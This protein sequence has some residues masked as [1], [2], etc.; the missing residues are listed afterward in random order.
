[1]SH[2]QA[3]ERDFDVLLIDD[4]CSFLTPRMVSVLKGSGV[5]V[6]GVY[7]PHDG[8][9]AKRRLLECG[10]SDVIE[11]DATPGEFLEKTMTVIAH[12]LP[13]A[14][15][16]QRSQRALTIG[17]TG[18]TAGV[19]MTEVAIGLAAAMSARKQSVLIDADQAW[20]SVAQR[21]DLPLHPNIRTALDHAMHEVSRLGESLQFVGELMVIGGRADEG[22]SP[23][24][25]RAELEGLLEAVSETAEVV[26]ADLGA[27]RDG[28]S[29]LMGGV[30]DTLIVVGTPDPV[31]VGRMLKLTRRL[32]ESHASLLMVL[33]RCPRGFDTA[34]SIAVLNRRLPG[35]PITTVPFD[36]KVKRA[37]W[38]GTQVD[39]GRFV[40]AMGGFTDV[41]IKAL[42]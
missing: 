14:E 4:I 19:G 29:W 20:P 24:V 7:A 8:P 15:S 2:E 35:T 6:V 10:I 23:M 12:R 1:M 31:G 9:D 30:W 18:A 37:A 3:L 25:S 40:R 26:V 27:L 21:L 32:I 28:E 33:N 36:E 13:V 17:V 16:V 41:V 34:E 38:D 5:D 22:Q 42:P 39:R 11:T